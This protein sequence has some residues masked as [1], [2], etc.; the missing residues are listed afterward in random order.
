MKQQYTSSFLF[1]FLDIVLYVVTDFLLSFFFLVIRFVN[2]Y[3]FFYV[4]RLC[5]ES[6]TNTSLT[7]IMCLTLFW[8]YFLPLLEKGGHSKSNSYSAQIYCKLIRKFYFVSLHCALRCCIRLGDLKGDMHR[9][10]RLTWLVQRTK[11]RTT[12]QCLQPLKKMQLQVIV[13]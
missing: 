7:L 12:E 10:Q 6:G 3:F 4:R 13:Q 2:F 11:E 9:L 1:Q 8:L 5:L